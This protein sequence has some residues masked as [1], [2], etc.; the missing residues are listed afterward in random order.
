MGS[1]P[2][3]SEFHR[4]IVSSVATQI[5]QV[6]V[7][8]FEVEG[9][10]SYVANGI[11]VHNCPSCWSMHGSV[12]DVDEPG[13]LDHQQ[14]RCAAIPAVKPWAELGFD[15]D[16]P[17]SV[18]PDARALFDDLPLEQQTAIM[19][20]EKLKLLQSGQIEWADLSTRRQTDGWR[21]SFVPTSL[22]DLQ[23]KAAA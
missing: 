17:A 6:T 16:E 21:D 20:A 11:A 12:H 5:Q 13:P 10:H 2:L 14:G 19:G 1:A 9:D 18:V 4:H 3:A 7:Y 15:I 23:A 8:N 22:A